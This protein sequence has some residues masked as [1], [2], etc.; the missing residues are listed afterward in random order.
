MCLIGHP[1][2]LD[3]DPGRLEDRPDIMSTWLVDAFVED[4]A[5]V[6]GPDVSGY[7]ISQMPIIIRMSD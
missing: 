4:V 2:R 1:Y 7:F 5:I 6:V 3:S